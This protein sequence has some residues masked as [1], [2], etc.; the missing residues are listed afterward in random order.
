MQKN[1]GIPLIFRRTKF[2]R[3]SLPLLASALEK[4]LPDLR[5]LC[6]D[7]LNSLKAIGEE[8]KHSVL[9]Y[10]FMTPH[11]GAVKREISMIR[12]TYGDS[13]MLLS[14]GS[15]STADPLGTLELGF[16]AVF[17]GESERTFPLFIEK[18][19]NERRIMENER[20][21]EDN[22]PPG[23]LDDHLPFSKTLGIYAPLEL[24]RGCFYGCSF[25]QTQRIFKSRVRHRSISSAIEGIRTYLS[26][27]IGRIY[28]LSPN[29]FC[30]GAERKGQI[31]L[32][33]IEELLSAARRTG[34][35]S[36]TLGTFPSEIRPDYVTPEIL[37]L[38]KKYCSNKKLVLGIQS[39][40]ESLIGKL[41]RGHTVEE[42][43]KAVELIHEFGFIPHCD[44]VFGFP[45]E[46][47]AEMLAS[48]HMMTEIVKKYRGRIHAHYFMPLPGTPLWGSTP[49]P[50]PQKVRK[51]LEEL[52]SWGRLDGWWQDQIEIARSIMEWKA[53]GY[54][55]V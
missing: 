51:T 38:V 53:K 33:A 24:T 21:I 34:T 7:S 37:A 16:D 14:G 11:F 36:V 48:A 20:I 26:K 13:F 46:T 22:Y 28:F 31:N 4:R 5:I 3:F 41:R 44:F 29:A 8:N 32:E 50:L 27:G 2:N 15:H 18:L 43:W 6:I 9:C 12:R 19:Q 23:T 30:Y 1:S 35:K 45:G 39:A 52:S 25:C 49:E 55:R 17:A 40:S 42:S 47:E 10:S 54:I